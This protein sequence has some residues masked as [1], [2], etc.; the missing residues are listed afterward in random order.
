MSRNNSPVFNLE[1]F[2][3][4]ISFSILNIANCVKRPGTNLYCRGFKISKSHSILKNLFCIIFPNILAGNNVRVT[5]LQFEGLFKFP[6]FG[7]ILMKPLAHSV[8]CN[9]LA[10]TPKPSFNTEDE[11]PSTLYATI[12]VYQFL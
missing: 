1:L 10:I 7:N 11:I 8:S 6:P 5:G 2:A 3:L 4:K 9:C 12:F